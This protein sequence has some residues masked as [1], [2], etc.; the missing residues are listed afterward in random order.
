MELSAAQQQA[1]TSATFGLTPANFQLSILMVFYALL[2]LWAGWL[3]YAQWIAWSNRKID[4]YQLL[5]RCVRCALV[6][7]FASFF[8]Q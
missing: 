4:F 7:L 6:T 2:Y 8:I 3:M 5:T 1:F